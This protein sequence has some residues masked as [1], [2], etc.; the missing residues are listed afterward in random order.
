[1]AEQHKST[2]LKAKQPADGMA[3]AS[4]VLGILSILFFWFWPLAGIMAVLALVFGIVSYKKT[5]SGISIAGISCGSVGLVLTVVMIVF[6]I[7]I[8]SSPE[9]QDA[10]EDGRRNYDS[11]L[12]DYN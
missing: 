7:A 10:L 8:V 9:F 6:T 2:P 1:M 4:M 5:K 3:V 11:G 12:Y